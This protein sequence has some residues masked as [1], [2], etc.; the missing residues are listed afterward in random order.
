MQLPRLGSEQAERTKDIV[1]V[2]PTFGAR[3]NSFEMTRPRPSHFVDVLDSK[4]IEDLAR[5]ELK[6]LK[7]QQEETSPWDKPKKPRYES[8]LRPQ[9]PGYHTI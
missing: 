9:L 3:L 2:K 7:L 5:K 1:P 6:K 4:A 8:N